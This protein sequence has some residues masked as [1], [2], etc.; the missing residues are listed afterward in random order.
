MALRGKQVRVLY[1]TRCCDFRMVFVQNATVFVLWEGAQRWNKSENLPEFL[2]VKGF[3]K[4]ADIW[5][6]ASWRV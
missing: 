4:R 2:K 1:S 6:N 5:R 3:G